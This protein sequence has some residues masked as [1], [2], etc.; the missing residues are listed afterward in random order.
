MAVTV[1]GTISDVVYGK[2]DVCLKLNPFDNYR[3]FTLYEDWRSDDRKPI[4]LSN[5]QKLY[6]V[7]K[8]KKKEIRIPEY[9]TVESDYNVDKVNGQVLFKISK[10]N[11]IDILAMDNKVFYITRVYDITDYTGSKVLS[12]DEEVLY[13]GQ[14]KDES[15]NAVD[16]YTSQIKNLMA[17]LE[18]RNK[19]I[20]DLQTANAK[21]LEQNADFS[22]KLSDLQDENDKMTSQ[23]SELEAK[24]ADYE[25]GTEYAGTVIDD[26]AQHV[27]ITRVGKVNNGKDYTEDQLASAIKSLEETSKE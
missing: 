26:N 27:I 11:A 2:G 24:V 25:S 8:S 9:D 17:I 7:F 5:G 21:L 6:L 22:I 15:A 14:W 23:L 13:T 18:D 3:M 16:N 4:D 20:R 10:K 1:K 19:Q 12:S